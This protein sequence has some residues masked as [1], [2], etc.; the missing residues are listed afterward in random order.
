[1]AIAQVCTRRQRRK[2]A[3]RQNEFNKRWRRENRE[4]YNEN[5]RKRRKAIQL[6]TI[7]NLEATEHDPQSLFAGENGGNLEHPS[8]NILLVLR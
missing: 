1:M 3:K 6:L 4:W 5:E 7:E 2:W 8:L